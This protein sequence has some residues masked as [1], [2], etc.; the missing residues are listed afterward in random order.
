ML[1]RK[2]PKGE[3]L[4]C[5]LSKTWARE[6]IKSAET[7]ATTWGFG[8]ARCTVE[9]HVSRA[10]IVAAMTQ[11]KMK[12]HVPAHTAHCVVEENG[13]PQPLRATLAPK[14]VFKDGKAEKVWINLMEVE[15]PVAIR[16]TLKA[17]AQLEDK[18][19]IFHHAMIKSINRFI[20]TSCARHYPHL[21]ASAAPPVTKAKSNGPASPAP[22]K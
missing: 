8:D 3:D 10:L 2:E 7:K 15:G 16:D 11:N 5:T 20:H 6:T 21:V 19:G 22:P 14:I 12:V 4:K 1:L 9:A 17:V 18:L 13:I